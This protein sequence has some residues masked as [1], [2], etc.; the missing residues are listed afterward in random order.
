MHREFHWM[1]VTTDALIPSLE[2]DCNQLMINMARVSSRDAIDASEVRDR[3]W[4]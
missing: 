3:H 1:E 2:G 4:R